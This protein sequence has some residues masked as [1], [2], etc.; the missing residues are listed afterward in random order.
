MFLNFKNEKLKVT[1]LQ[2][3]KKWDPIEMKFKIIFPQLK[4]ETNFIGWEEGELK[5][6]NDEIKLGKY[7]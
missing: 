7:F 1:V 2:L 3:P 6:V 4:N 5:K